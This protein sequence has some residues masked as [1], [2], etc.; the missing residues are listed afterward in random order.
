MLSVQGLNVH[1]GGSHAV[2]NV[3][4]D[5]KE[6]ENV[7]LTGRNGA[8][9]STIIKA[10]VGLLPPTSGSIKFKGVE[11]T[12]KPPHE[13]V[14]LGSGYAPEDRKIFTD[15]TTYENLLIPLKY[16][17]PSGERIFDLEKIFSIFP[18]LS[19]L[20]NRKGLFLS[21][22]EQKMLAVARTLA[23]SPSLVLVDEPPEGLAPMAVESF[24]KSMKMA[25][26]EG[27]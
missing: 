12:Q 4:F 23:L 13:I 1:I 27:A 25:R 10:I 9:K 16:S 5:V 14:K 21:G 26:E 2:R 8:G 24:T 15:L 7:C 22:G 18:R 20:S 6:G 19:P 11:I 17:K 3:S